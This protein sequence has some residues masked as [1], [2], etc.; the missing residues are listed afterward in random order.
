MQGPAYPPRETRVQCLVKGE[1]ERLLHSLQRNHL[2]LF[3]KMNESSHN[4]I[5]SQNHTTFDALV[6]LSNRSYSCT[7]PTREMHLTAELWYYSCFSAPVQI[8]QSTETRI[9]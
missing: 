8:V 2:E 9:Q 6:P 7:N 4:P 1:P 5:F 3:L